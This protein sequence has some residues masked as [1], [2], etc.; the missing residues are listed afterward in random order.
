MKLSFS[1]NWI[2]AALVAAIPAVVLAASPASAPK[3]EPPAKSVD[4]FIGM[5]SGEVEAV[6]IPKDSTGGTI[7]IKN[8]TDKPLSVKIPAAFAGVPILAQIGMGGGMGGGG[9]G[10]GGMG[11]MGGGGGMQGMGGGMMG[12][13]GMGGGGMGGGGMGGM[14]NIAPDKVQKVKIAAVCL[15]HGKADPNP[16]VPYKPVPI[17]S[18]AKDPAVAELLVLMCQGKIDQHSAQAAAWHIQNGLSWEE[19][20]NKVGIKH[21]DGRKEPYFVGAHLERAFVATRVAKE[22]AEKTAKEKERSESQTYKE[23]TGQK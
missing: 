18:Y 12:G 16:R 5:D 7:M 22:Q 19:L 1:Q 23:L 8:K 2:L 10:G 14:F 15:D 20:A 21:I 9:M 4:L 17:D 13:G 11:G 3:K 6:L